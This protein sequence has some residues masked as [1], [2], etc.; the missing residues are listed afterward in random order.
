MSPTHLE[1]RLFLVLQAFIDESLD[2]GVFAMGGF[3]ST[4]EKWATFASEWEGVLPQGVRK[5]PPRAS[6]ASI[7]HTFRPTDERLPEPSLASAYR[8]KMSEMASTSEGMER[9]TPFLRI[10]ERNVMH[11]ISCG[12]RIDDLNRAKDRVRIPG[13]NLHWGDMN[14]PYFAGFRVLMDHFHVRR[15]AM[16]P[17]DFPELATSKVDFYFDDRSDKDVIRNAWGGYLDWREPRDRA[18]YGHE[19]RFEDDETFLPLQAADL[20][21]WWVR[22][23]FAEGNIKARLDNLQFGAGRGIRLPRSHVSIKEDH[24]VVG[25]ANMIG[26][27]LTTVTPIYD[28]KTGRV[29]CLGGMGRPARWLVGA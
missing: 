26:S 16:T 23:W 20:W 27:Q 8:F 21:A 29:I 15:P 4:P 12:F 13:Y 3:I 25:L 18:L 10:I 22:E 19:P 2:D 9:L 28:R 6:G 14:N 11:A 17:P 24:W 1:R 7:L 5:P